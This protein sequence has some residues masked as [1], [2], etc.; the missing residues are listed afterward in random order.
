MGDKSSVGD[1][2]VYEAGDQVSITGACSVN[3]VV[4]LHQRKYT[5]DEL[6]QQDRFK[7]G[8]EHSHKADDPS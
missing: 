5:S 8:K 6:E 1:R 7:E 3:S 4:T 2:R